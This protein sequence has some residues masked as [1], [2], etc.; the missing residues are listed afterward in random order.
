MGR[1]ANFLTGVGRALLL[2]PAVA[3]MCFCF[4]TNIPLWLWWLS[5]RPGRVPFD[6]ASWRDP[7][8]AL[9]NARLRMAEDLLASR[10]LPGKTRAEATSLLGE[11]SGGLAY[12][13]GVAPADAFSLVSD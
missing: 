1:S 2:P 3:W 5:G 13:L 4:A 11:P 6:A 12:D 8:P 7:P 10:S 9:P